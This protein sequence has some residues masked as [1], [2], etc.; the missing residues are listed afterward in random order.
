[1]LG[2]SSEIK[3]CDNIR[4]KV[5][6]VWTYDIIAVLNK[7]DLVIRLSYDHFAEAVAVSKVT[8]EMGMI[9]ITANHSLVATQLEVKAALATMFWLRFA[10]ENRTRWIRMWG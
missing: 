3:R 10:P 7:G 8:D 6:A 9:N 2:H 1:V 4:I 5:R